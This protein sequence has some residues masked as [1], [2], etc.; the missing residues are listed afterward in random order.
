MDFRIIRIVLWPKDKQLK[1]RTIDFDIDKVNVITGSNGK[2]KSSIISIIDYCI[3]SSKCTI[4]S[5]I[6]R[7]KTQCF[8][9]VIQFNNR[10]ILLGREEPGAS[11]ISN[12]FFKYED[13]LIII[14]DTIEEYPFSVDNIK[15]YLNSI[16]GFAD[17]GFSSNDYVQSF[18]SQR[19]SYRNAISLNFQPQYLVANQSTMFYR[20]DSSSHR[21]KL[22]ILF[23]YLIGVIN[24][25]MMEL[26]EEL[27]D[28]RR[29]LNILQKEKDVRALR[30]NKLTQELANYFRLGREFGLI[31]IEDT[32][33]ISDKNF[34]TDQLKRILTSEIESVRIPAQATENAA[35]LLYELSNDE[36]LKS[37]QLQD[38][39]RKLSIIKS[40]QAGNK[41]IGDNALVKRS[42]LTTID[43]FQDKLQFDKPCPLCHSVH[44]QSKEYF[45]SLSNLLGE[46]EKVSE[47]VADSA[48]IYLNESRKL[49]KQMLEK[50]EEINAIRN[51]IDALRRED[52]E[53]RRLKQ[54]QNSINRYL[55][56]VELTVNHF[57]EFG[58]S[59]DDS[60]QKIGDIEERIATIEREVGS[61]QLKNRE[62]YALNKISENIKKYAQLFEAEKSSENIKLDIKEFLTLKFLDSGGR[63]RFLWEV[64]SGHNYM[65]YHLSTYLGIHE[66][67]LTIKENK[68]P[69]FIIFDQ[70]SQAYFPEIKDDRSV[71]EEDL[72]KLKKIFEVLSAFNTNTHG[73]VQVIVL[74]HAGEESWKGFDNVVK[75]KRWR[76]DEDDDALIPQAWKDNQ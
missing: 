4:P 39:G 37:D 31:D 60:D 69:P 46:F 54:N 70:P 5:G 44:T 16:F 29:K 12:N 13:E 1:P 18:D 14:P 76:S 64:G 7:D 72:L 24:N 62:R 51:R 74:E 3:A 15:H 45:S 71:Q 42:R 36:L 47:K 56:Q 38:M 73:K 49:E 10:Q 48:K 66:Y 40:I 23:P 58:R 50:E 65:A 52:G 67:L 43:W 53:F 2:G 32:E 68:V 35:R 28:L 55:G 75:V 17:I 22:K 25:Q 19:P 21:E 8:G 11:G 59:V 20:A 27:K 30:L 6:I 9:V 26:K 33:D 57:E 34:L 63:E 61:D 41:E